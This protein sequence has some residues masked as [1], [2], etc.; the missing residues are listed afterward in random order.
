MCQVWSG[1]CT[2]LPGGHHLEIRRVA[3]LMFVLIAF[4]TFALIA[5]VFISIEEK[6]RRDGVSLVSELMVDAKRKKRRDTAM[7][8]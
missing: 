1:L 5:G 2:A 7:E 6:R 4:I 8:N 3:M